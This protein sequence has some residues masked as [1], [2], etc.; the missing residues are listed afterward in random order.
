MKRNDLLIVLAV[1]L[2]LVFTSCSKDNSECHECHLALIMGD[3]TEHEHEIGEF[4]D[5]D[6]ENVEANGYVVTEEFTHMGTTYEVGYE[7]DASE[8][9]CEEH[10]DHDDHD[11]DDDGK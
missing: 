2:G 1:C 8:V 6:L 7:F 3:G 5:A 10:G 11:H 9:H 4:C